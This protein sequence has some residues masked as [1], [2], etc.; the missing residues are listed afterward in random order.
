METVSVKKY[1]FHNCES[2]VNDSHDWPTKREGSSLKDPV[3]QQISRIIQVVKYNLCPPSLVS[4]VLLSW[5]LV[6][7]YLYESTSRLNC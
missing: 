5:Q 3:V 1:T 4:R 7:P 2:Y 6:D